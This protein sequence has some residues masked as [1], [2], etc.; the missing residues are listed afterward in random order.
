VVIVGACDSADG[1][2]AEYEWLK[3]NLPD[4]KRKSQSLI[5]GKRTYDLF[6][7]VLPN[8]EERKVYFDISSFFGKF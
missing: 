3:T 7:V 8:G 6:V 1:V 5:T 4:A 2:P